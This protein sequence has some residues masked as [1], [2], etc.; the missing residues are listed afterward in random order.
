MEKRIL[1]IDNDR[2]SVALLQ[3]KLAGQCYLV[4]VIEDGETGL[5]YLEKEPPDLLIL[6]IEA[7]GMCGADV[8]KAIRA[9]E[10]TRELAVVVY[11][12]IESDEAVF[13]YWRYNPACTFTKPGDPAEL[14]GTV[15]RIFQSPI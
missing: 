13:R 15:N 11:T 1:I 6:G 10:A 3:A 7:P 12:Y 4:M 14:A 5:R 2:T 9:N 8:L